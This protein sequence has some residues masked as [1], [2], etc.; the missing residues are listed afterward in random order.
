MKN[1][2]KRK[3]KRKKSLARRFFKIMFSILTIYFIGLMS[4]FAYA[5]FNDKEKN[6][7]D[8][9]I[10]DTIVNKVS[11][12]LPERT[13][14]LVACTDSGDN[15]SDAIMLVC[16]NSISKEI[17]TVSIPRDTRVSIPDDMWEVMVQNFPV[18]ENDNP[19]MKKINSITY[20]GKDKGME[21]LE[22]YLENLLDIQIDYYVRFSFDGFRYII[23]S[24]GGIEFDVPMRMKYSDPTQDLYI[25]LQPGM[26]LLDGDKAEQ[27]LRFR[28][29]NYNHGYSRGDLERIEV[30]QKF[31][32]AFLEKALNVDT[33]LSNPKAYFNTLTKYIDTNFGIS[34][35]LKYVQEAKNINIA[36]TK[37]YT[38]PCTQ[39]TIN[40]ISYVIIDEDVAKEFAYDVFKK[41]TVK[42]ED[43]VYEDSFNKSIQVLNGSY[44]SG[45]AGKT[46]NILRENGYTV[47]FI[48]DYD[49]S[50]ETQT[51][52]YVSKDG[53]GTD[54]QKFF[55]NSKI[56]VNPEKV[57]EFGY[58]ITIVIGT[59]DTIKDDVSTETTS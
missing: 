18:I 6:T 41:P 19:N 27:L 30:Q 47:D 48:G 12:K 1:T 39:E 11:P 53:Q 43:I 50:K 33:I 59:Q 52:I 28:K 45:L 58:D 8:N 24:I 14:G 3:K 17:S 23:D 44:T 22:T 36:N 26:Q 46:Q 32:K 57:L 34:D 25:D 4:F 31:M 37:S 56:L 51:R 35:A 2:K 15:R 21:F 49:G 55:T 7:N 42:P 20:Y 54:L 10:I 9:T 5:Y 16:Y 40:G 29:D 13:I 38:I